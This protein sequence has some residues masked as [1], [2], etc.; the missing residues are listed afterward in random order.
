MPAENQLHEHTRGMHELP[1]ADRANSANRPQQLTDSLTE[2]RAGK[3]FLRADD[4]LT[5]LSHKSSPLDGLNADEGQ[6]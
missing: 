6:M 2:P 1:R 4:E 3:D 5:K